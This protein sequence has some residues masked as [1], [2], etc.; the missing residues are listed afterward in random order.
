MKR[1]LF[2]L[3]LSIALFC[4]ASPAFGQASA[5]IGAHYTA[6]QDTQQGRFGADFAAGY[7]VKGLYF[8]GEASG[9]DGNRLRT[10]Y[11]GR[12]GWNV[13]DFRFSGGGGYFRFGSFRDGGFGQ[14]GVDY[15]RF[16][17][18]GRIGNDRFLE[19]EA[20]YDL[21]SFGDHVGLQICGRGTRHETFGGQTRR[22]YQAGMRLNIR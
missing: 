2:F 6:N 16:H 20:A 22:I 11:F 13:G 19:A 7:E 9:N 17:G 4:L 14:A 15:K 21:A 10:R 18:F 1:T 8:G 5:S 12:Y 3:V